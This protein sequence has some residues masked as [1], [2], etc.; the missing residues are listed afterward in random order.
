[1]AFRN[2]L[3]KIVPVSS[4]ENR[5][6][7]SELHGQIEDLKNQ[8]E[9]FRLDSLERIQQTE[10]QCEKYMLTERQQL[11]GALS[12][13][14]DEQSYHSNLLSEIDSSYK[15]AIQILSCN[16]DVINDCKAMQAQMSETLHEVAQG[17]IFR[18]IEFLQ[19]RLIILESIIQESQLPDTDQISSLKFAFIER[20]RGLFPVMHVDG[21]YHFVRVGRKNDGGYV[22][23]D[24]FKN[25]KIAYSI[26]IADD[27]SWDRDMAKRGFEVYMYDHTIDGLPENNDKFHYFKTGLGSSANLLD[28]SMKTLDRML[29]DNGHE[30]E[31][32]MVL[33][34]DIE[35]AEYDVFS[36]IDESVLN[37]FSQIVIEFHGLVQSEHEQKIKGALEKLNQTHQLVHLHPNNYGSYMLSGHKVLPE[38][39]EATYLLKTEYKFEHKKMCFPT[40]LDM[41]NCIYLPDIILG[42]WDT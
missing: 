1:M 31:R 38:L 11:G 36:E 32:G 30:N 29:Q 34:V 35:G 40:E 25:R 26:G 5:E 28:P 12:K 24:D 16:H 8:L 7:Y 23:V 22:M 42:T 37:R 14:A 2:F 21:G 6:Q 20:M 9:S 13:L 27:V 15:A 39:I 41:I 10:A 4:A 18:R 33:K 17:D 3:R 19:N